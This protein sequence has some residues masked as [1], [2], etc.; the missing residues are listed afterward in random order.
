MTDLEFC[1]K[2]FRN[3][4]REPYSLDPDQVQSFVVPDLGPNYYQ[5]MTLVWERSGSEVE[6]LTRDRSSSPAAL[7]CVLE[8]DILIPT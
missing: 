7:R 1:Q 8:Q 2:C 5:Q 6:G 4:I 3:T